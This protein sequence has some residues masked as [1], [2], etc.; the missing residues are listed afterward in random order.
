M[1]TNGNES[2]RGTAQQP[3]R[4]LASSRGKSGFPL[5]SLALLITALGSLLACV[6]VRRLRDQ[7]A[8]LDTNLSE[9]VAWIAATGIFGAVVGFVY[10]FASGFTWRKLFVAPLAGVVAGE[11]GL[12]I[13]VA[14]GPMWRTIF[15]ISILFV[16]AIIF[17][18]GAE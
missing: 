18:I 10:L 13:M 11:L 12:M 14:P 3:A 4:R 1:P 8:W 7:I 9:G 16:S 6:D 17:R 2:T 15:A 5:A